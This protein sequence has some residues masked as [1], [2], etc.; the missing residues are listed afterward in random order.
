MS[1]GDFMLESTLEGICMLLVAHYFR[2]SAEGFLCFAVSGVFNTTCVHSAYEIPF[3][4][5]PKTHYYHHKKLNV[6]YGIGFFD[7]LFGTAL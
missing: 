7:W 1:F 6:N 4:P 3:L 5:S 2:A